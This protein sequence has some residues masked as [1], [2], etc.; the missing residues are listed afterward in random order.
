MVG[1]GIDFGTT[2]SV[3]AAF[4][5][6]KVTPFTDNN[7]LPHPSVIWYRGD[8]K[9]IVGRK[10]KDKI[11]ELG[12]VPGNQFIKSIKSQIEKEEEF[13]I[14]GKPYYTWQIASEIFSFLKDYIAN[15][16]QYKGFPDLDE[17]VVT[18]PLKFTGRQ[19]KSI[20]KAAQKAGIR[21][22]SFIHEPFAAVVGYLL[23]DPNQYENLKEK[24][25]NI[26]VF[27]WGGGTLDITLVKLDSGHLYEVSSIAENGKSGDYFD[28]VLMRDVI[29]TFQH[30]KNIK[31]QGFRLEKGVES[32]LLNEVEIG[33]IELS[34]DEISEI[35]VELVDFY[36]DDK[37]K[38][39]NLS[40]D[41]KKEHFES[42]IQEDV[43]DA[44]NL[45]DKVLSESKIKSSQVHQ[46]LL[47]GGTSQIPLLKS[48]MYQTFGFTKVIELGNADTIIAEGAA[49]ISYN[50]WQPYLVRPICIKLCDES[51][52]TI[53]D[54]GTILIPSSAK[55]NVALFCNDNTEGEGRLIITEQL[56]DNEYKF[57]KMINI[58]V[59]EVL[60]D[61][62]TERIF[63]EFEVDQDIVLNISAKGS[64]KNKA[65]YPDI[66]DICY[67]LKF[68]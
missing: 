53:F 17:A 7:K 55:K 11:R 1:F 44:M 63:A 62:Y 3:A 24:R 49:I 68:A 37:N 25:E 38:V 27:D 32:S 64:I 43:K 29:S 15:N 60:R 66:H 47:I 67:G 33:K 19:R 57:K 6:R 46:V 39:Y 31:S 12:N 23:A 28:E 14:F 30:E 45:V 22:K 18:I 21:V 34:K 61:I 9:P 50:N 54:T 56:S 36:E 52:Y 51:H 59:S 40:Q 8:G 20:R 26:L 48:E 13:E 10:A 4:N 2:N 16:K 65:V 5:G 58:P 41:I 35:S 42:L